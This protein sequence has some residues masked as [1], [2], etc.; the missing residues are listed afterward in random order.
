[1]EAHPSI[2]DCL[3]LLEWLRIGG[4]NLKRLTYVPESVTHLDLSNSGLERL[5]YCIIGLPRL[6]SLFVY[7]C[8]K[9]VSL[10]G[11][12][13]SLKYIN[14]N[15]CESLER[16]SFVF[17]DSL[18]EIEFQNCLNLDEESRRVIMQQKV[19]HSVCLPGKE[20]PAEFTN[21][22]IGNSIVIPTGLSR[23]SRLRFKACLL[24]SP[25]TYSHLDIACVVTKGGVTIAKLKWD[26]MNV[27]HFLTEHLFL[28]DGNLTPGR[29][30]VDGNANDILFEFSCRD[31]FKIT[32]CGLQILWENSWEFSDCETVGTGDR[33]N[34]YRYETYEPEAVQ[35][36]QR[37][38]V[39]GSNYSRSCWSWLKKLCSRKRDDRNYPHY[40]YHSRV[41]ETTATSHMTPIMIRRE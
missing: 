10:L 19:H 4:I 6:E 31:S 15:D 26:S 28:C 39:Q 7:Q 2:S 36:S 5:P 27:S 1:M 13:P 25:V 40:D 17:S 8:R 22:A 34:R 11:L 9:L 14:A 35:I 16:V 32:E 23:N 30:S 41:A 21:R 37:E 18:R 3:P 12:P 20:I 33:S 29:P 38:D 24:I